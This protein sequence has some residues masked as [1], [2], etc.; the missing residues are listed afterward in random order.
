LVGVGL[1]ADFVDD[2]DTLFEADALA[3]DLVV[4]EALAEI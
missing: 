2:A 3:L 4:D 1:A